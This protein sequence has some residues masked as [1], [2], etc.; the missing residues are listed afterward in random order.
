MHHLVIVWAPFQCYPCWKILIMKTKPKLD[1]C[2]VQ[3]KIFWF[4][5][6]FTVFLAVRILYYVKTIH[7]WKGWNGFQIRACFKRQ[8]FPRDKLYKLEDS[9]KFI[10]IGSILVAPGELTG[11]LWYFQFVS[12]FNN[13]KYIVIVISLD[14]PSYREYFYTYIL[15]KQ[16]RSGNIFNLFC[17]ENLKKFFLESTFCQRGNI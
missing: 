15:Y 11:L 3:F 6:I 12:I 16:L 13:Y 14:W 8:V 1:S 7:F 4:C 10:E 2:D 17:L 5:Q 9:E